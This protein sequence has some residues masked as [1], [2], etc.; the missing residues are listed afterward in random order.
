MAALAPRCIALEY[1]G[2]DV[3]VGIE[4]VVFVYLHVYLV[5]QEEEDVIVGGVSIE[6]AEPVVEARCCLV[7]YLAFPSED[8]C[9]HIDEVVVG[10]FLMV[11]VAALLLHLF[12][13]EVV[14]GVELIGDGYGHEVELL[15]P[16][17]ECAFTSHAEHLDDAA[18]GDVVGVFRP[19]LPLC[20]PDVFFLLLYGVVHIAAYLDAGGE[21]LTDGESTM[22]DE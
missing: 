19:T 13:F 8:A 6:C 18:L 7:V 20:Y 9:L 11:G 14:A 5:A 12:G 21:L 15:Q 17:D 3:V 22:H 16:L 1:V 4:F 10:S 2:G